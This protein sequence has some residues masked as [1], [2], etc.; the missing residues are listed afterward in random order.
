MN[1]R[2][3]SA[4][5]GTGI[6]LLWALHAVGPHLPGPTY[7]LLPT[8]LAAA[9]AFLLWRLASTESRFRFANKSG[10]AV[11][12]G[13]WFAG[14]TL[15]AILNWQTP[16]VFVTY[17]TVFLTGAA[18]F[19]ALSGV[20]LTEGAYEV[21][22]AGL[23]AGALVPLVGGILAFFAEWGMPDIPTAMSAYRDVLRM[24]LYETATFGNRGNTA[25]FLVVLTPILLLTLLDARRRTSLRALC[26]LVLTL[27]ACN[28]VILQ[29]RAAFVALSFAVV[30][31]WIFRL[32]ARRLPVLV[33]TLGIVWVVF[34][35]A[36]PDF[37]ARISGQMLPVLT[38]DTD[39]DASVDQRVMAIQEG[40]HIFEQ[41]W[42]LGIGPGGALTKH[43]Q[44][45]AHQ[46][47]VQQAMEAGVLGL[48]GSSLF[49][50]SVLFAL[51]RTMMRRRGA[52]DDLRFAML[53]GPAAYV[54]YAIIANATLGFSTVNV[55]TVLNAS[56]LALAPSFDSS[57]SDGAREGSNL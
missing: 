33:A 23:A 46:F 6:A 55:W 27:V 24:S 31:V 38:V 35:T 5:V 44:D 28:L 50:L 14:A 41:H 57:A 42:I 18:I 4:V 30:C 26:G 51:G 43:P 21:A 19:V 34:A 2:S 47:Q 45:S 53:I 56:M 15:S 36:D 12:L 17:C 49:T 22:V 16:Q 25:A 37:A 7:L 20:T 54:V 39:A 13:C 32:G 11:A 9:A 10:L 1:V 48:V 52:R 29:V 8:V 3:S 40:W